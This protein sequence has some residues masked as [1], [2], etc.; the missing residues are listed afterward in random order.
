MRIIKFSFVKSAIKLP[1]RLV[2]KVLFGLYKS[3]WR[4]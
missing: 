4:P 3:E 1:N 2:T